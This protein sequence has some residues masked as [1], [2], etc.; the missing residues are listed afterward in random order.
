MV[1]KIENYIGGKLVPAQDGRTS[2]IINP[3]TEEVY[4]TAPISSAQDVDAACGAAQQAFEDWRARTPGERSLILHKVANRMEELAQELAEIEVV[5]TGKP[6]HIAV[7][8]EIAPAVDSVR[9][10]AGASRILEGRAAGEFLAGHTS[11][12][13]REP[14]GVCAQITPWNYPLLMAVWKWAPAIAAGNTV[15]LKPSETTPMSMAR[16]AEILGEFLPPGVVNVIYGDR[17]SGSL[18]A[19]HPVPVMTSLTGSVA[20]GK[21]VAEASAKRLK[22][23]H[24]E[25]GGKAPVIVFDDVDIKETA[26]AIADAAF[27]NAGQ[28]CEAASRVLVSASIH[29]EFLAELARQAAA[30]RTGDPFSTDTFF[31]PLNSATQLKRVETFI[32]TLPDHASVVQGGS[33]AAGAG[34]FFEPTVI[35]GVKQSDDIVQREVFGPVVTVQRFDSEQDAI[36]KANDCVYALAASVWTQNHSR[37]MR[38]TSQLEFGCVWVNTH[39]PFVAEMPHGGFKESGYGNDLSTYGL[40]EYL[41]IKHVMHKI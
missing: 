8:D 2:E 27:Y 34:Y 39:L 12:I 24:L 38:M 15:V 21:A 30:R 9:F 41:R 18:L 4:A 35:A 31:G 10:F 17:E 5:N 25:L 1:Q 23:S 3:A 37:A 14:I 28:D 20:A 22:R 13:R 6:L 11:Y 29:D 36:T 32:S 40:E 16:T 19:H 26:A 7:D 33:R